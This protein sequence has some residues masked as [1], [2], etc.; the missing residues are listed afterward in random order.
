MKYPT[1]YGTPKVHY[2]VHK[3]PLSLSSARLIQSL[4]SHS[5][6]LTH[7]C[8]ILPSTPTTSQLTLSCMFSYQNTACI[9]LHPYTCHMTYP[10]IFPDLITLIIFNKKYKSWSSSQSIFYSLLLITPS[11]AQTSSSPPTILQCKVLCF[12]RN[13]NSLKLRLM[14]PRHPSHTAVTTAYQ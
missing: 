4:P 7:F 3:S 1:P 12:E 2:C 14:C 9:A 13:I 11:L 6:S 5:V 10:S 8:I